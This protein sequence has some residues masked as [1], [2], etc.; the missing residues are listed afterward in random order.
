MKAS[1]LCSLLAGQ[2]EQKRLSRENQ[3]GSE[4]YPAEEVVEDQEDI[5]LYYSWS[6]SRQPRNK[7]QKERK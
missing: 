5:F 6:T 3:G 4:K 1:D 7:I 2:K